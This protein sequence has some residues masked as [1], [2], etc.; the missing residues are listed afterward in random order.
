MNIQR[1]VVPTDFSED[2]HEALRYAAVLAR[3]AGAM[4]SVVHI[5][6]TFPFVAERNRHDVQSLVEREMQAAREH[7]QRDIEPF[8][9]Q[10]ILI[11]PVV[12]TGKAKRELLRF[13]QHHDADLVVLGTHGHSL[14]ERMIWGSVTEHLM[15]TSPCPTLTINTALTRRS[16]EHLQHILVPTDFSR[17]AERAWQYA[18]ALAKTRSSTLHLVH[19]LEPVL[20]VNEFAAVPMEDD[21]E[22]DAKARAGAEDLF[23]PFVAEA[24]ELG[25]AV[26]TAVLKGYTDIELAVYMRHNAIDLVCL[27]AHGKR[28][29]EKFLLGSTTARVLKASLC[30]VLVV[31]PPAAN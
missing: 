14:I 1:I 21:E 22:R 19:V 7:V 13:V 26:E 17:H 28:G 27:G 24:E 31:R 16:A 29:F 20:M 10:Q 12:L 6:E 15:R 5:V 18:L 3:D 30:P 11:E 9:A 25:V 2:A 4:L 8:V 23:E